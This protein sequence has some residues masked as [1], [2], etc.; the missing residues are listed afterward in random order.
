MLT[1]SSD[2]DSET[3]KAMM[4]D[5][6]VGSLDDK[7]KSVLGEGEVKDPNSSEPRP[8]FLDPRNWTRAVLHSKHTVSWDTRIFKFKLEHEDQKLGLPTG[9][10]LMIRL[11]DPATREAII[12]PYTPISH[13]MQSGFLDV[14]VKVYFDSRERKGGKMSQAMDALPIGHFTDFK[15][16]IGKFQYLGRGR[17]SINGAERRVKR[18]VMVCG[19]SGITPIFQVFRAV[20]NDKEDKTYCTVI[21]GNRLVEDILCREELYRFAVDNKTRCKLLHTLTQAPESWPG[22]RGRVAAPLLKKHAPLGPETMALICGPE[23]LEKSVH[24]ALNDHGWSDED[25]LFF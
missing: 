21:N 1:S 11:R 5:Y 14:L 18:F 4:P 16:P 23:A 15:G 2:T 3:A 22:L 12:R 7:A 8:L 25:L 9:Q 13:E 24:K 20:M 10:H 6:H 17:C 19:G